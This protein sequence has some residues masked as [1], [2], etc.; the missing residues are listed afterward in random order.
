MYRNLICFFAVV[1]LLGL[2]VG[3]SGK[4]AAANQGN[5][6]KDPN[7]VCWLKFDESS[8][9]KTVAGSS[10]HRR[11]GTLK[12]SM[13]FVSGRI[14]N[15]LKCDGSEGDYVEVTGYKGIAGTQARTVVAWIKTASNR[16]E[17]ISWG[18]DDFGQMFNFIF[19]RSRGLGITPNGGYYY[20]NPRVDDDTWHHVAAVV[21]DAELPNLHDDVTLYYD[22]TLAE[23]QDIGLLDL[24]PID[25]GSDLDV[26]IGRNYTGLIDDLRIYDRAL[27]DEEIAALYKTE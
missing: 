14:G 11:K 4:M 7:L 27:S 22:G 1:V 13:S 25:T 23:V 9:K 17:I 19:N 12:G 21:K 2:S 8:K 18:L 24:W 5:L 3:I 6:D 15:A 20:M 16:G 26:R 10:K